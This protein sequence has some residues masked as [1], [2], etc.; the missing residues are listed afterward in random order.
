MHSVLPILNIEVDADS[1]A[2]TTNN[3]VVGSNNLSF[4]TWMAVVFAPGELECKLQK[5]ISSNFNFLHPIA[6]YIV[7][8]CY[9][10]NPKRK[11]LIKMKTAQLTVLHSST[12]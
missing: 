5:S 2:D 10:L 8:I 1:Y 12:V 9:L 3:I 4:I 6:I 11:V 7:E